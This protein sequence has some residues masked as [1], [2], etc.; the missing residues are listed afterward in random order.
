VISLPLLKAVSAVAEPFAG[1]SRPERGMETILIAEDDHQARIL[2]KEI[3]T[4][5]EMKSGAGMKKADG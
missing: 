3:L 1:Q 5:F 4:A 2:L